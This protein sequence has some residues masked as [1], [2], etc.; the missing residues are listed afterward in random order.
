M[1]SFSQGPRCAVS[2]LR[3][4]AIRIGL[5]A[6]FL[7]ACA[8]TARAQTTVHVVQDQS[9]IWQSNFETAAAV[10]NA[11]T[12]LT[13][14][15]RRGDWYEVDVPGEQ[16]TGF[17]YRRNVE[18]PAS[19][20]SSPAV[21]FWGFVQF[22]YTQFAA[23][24]SF[25]AVLGQPGGGFLGGGAEMRLGTGFFLNG[26]AERFTKTGQGVFVANGEVFKLGTPDTITMMP[27][28]LTAGW[29]FAHEHVT[30]YVG[31]GVGRVFYKEALAF[32]DA[33]E[34][35]DTRSNSYHALGGVEFRNNWVATAFEVHYS[36]VPNALGAAGA[37]AA[38]GESN[39]GGLGGRIKILVGR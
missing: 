35:V 2:A 22:G 6:C 21:G 23:R 38:F 4:N 20:Q 28:A 18:E 9:T 32:G 5:I 14:V 13:V 19:M 31:A 29:R 12:V 8:A 11:G 7:G 39:L 15:G 26:S 25:E 30:P 37:S 27:I 16:R 33:G 10:V 24:N 17:I 1:G 3:S 36:R 34:D